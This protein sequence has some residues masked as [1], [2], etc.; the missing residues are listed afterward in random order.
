MLRRAASVQQRP[1]WCGLYG[2]DDRAAQGY[3][4]RMPP[5]N[6]P[7]LRLFSVRRL[8]GCCSHW[9]VKRVYIFL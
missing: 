2:S 3:A 4:V 7:A 8:L 1:V 9:I 6:A 5:R